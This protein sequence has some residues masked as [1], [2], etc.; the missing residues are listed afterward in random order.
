M[1]RIEEELWDYIDGNVTAEEKD[2]IA[3]KINTDLQYQSLY[4]ELTTLNESIQQLDFEEPSL[5]FTR[6]V[7]EN[8][9]LQLPPVALKT[10]VDHRIIYG[11]AALF[12]AC[13]IAVFA[14]AIAISSFSFQMPKLTVDFS[15]LINP[16]T[17]QIFV[18]VDVAL[19][20]IYL[21]SY[22]RK[23]RDAGSAS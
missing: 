14:Y 4:Q 12:A 6:N 9:S 17:V 10:K 11:I 8:V 5:S 1:N 19:G 2:R 23:K 3:S 16:I 22:L 20:L 15:K 7:M 18:M 21:D 13:I